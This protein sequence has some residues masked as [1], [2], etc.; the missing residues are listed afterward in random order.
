[1]VILS[2]GAEDASYYG[3]FMWISKGR[4]YLRVST[5]TKEWTVATNKFTVDTFMNIKF[6]WNR[7][8]G[9]QI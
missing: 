6:S 4:L 9:I 3:M 7:G 2:S 1:M 8:Q 5:K